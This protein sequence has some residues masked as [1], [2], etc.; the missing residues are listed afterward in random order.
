MAADTEQSTFG[1]LDDGSLTR[2]E[3]EL[4]VK[5]EPCTA[6]ALIAT[7]GAERDITASDLVEEAENFDSSYRSKA[8]FLGHYLTVAYEEGGHEGGG[9][10]VER[11]IGIH[12]GKKED[13]VAFVRVT[14]YYYSYD[15]TT[16]DDDSLMQVY[17]RQVTVTQYFENP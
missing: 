13:C 16:Y 10:Y 7:D 11:V 14:G 3:L 9:E 6:V 12:H 1:S 2:E 4:L 17:P 15:G 8:P 5:T